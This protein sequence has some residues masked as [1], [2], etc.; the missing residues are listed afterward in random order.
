M[1]IYYKRMYKAAL[2]SNDVDVCEQNFVVDPVLAD[3]PENRVQRRIVSTGP[4]VR[5]DL[6][7]KNQLELTATETQTFTDQDNSNDARRRGSKMSF[8]RQNS[9]SLRTELRFIHNEVEFDRTDDYLQDIYQFSL[10]KDLGNHQFTWR[11]GESHVRREGVPENKSPV[12][13]GIW[14]IT[15]A[16]LTATL[17][18]RR[19]ITN[20]VIGNSDLIRVDRDF[21]NSLI[22]PIRKLR[23]TDTPYVQLSSK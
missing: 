13:E 8:I 1:E 18:Y 11:A 4:K 22:R 6:K 15:H 19:Q 9:E 20:G 5:I 2:W 10:V 23:T 16:K 14:R 3:L 17:N 7:L 12:Y 21:E